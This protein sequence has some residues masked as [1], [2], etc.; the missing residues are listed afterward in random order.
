ME[1]K[2]NKTGNIV[3][4]VFNIIFYLLIGVL[5]VFSVSNFKVKTE[6][7]I[8]NIFG[9]GYL[10]P[11]TDS[12]TGKEKDSFT[13]N[14]LIFVNVLNDKNRIEKLESLKVGD[15]ITFEA[16][17]N[18]LGSKLQLNT[19]R[20]K[21]VSYDESGKLRGFITQ[22]DKARDL[23]NGQVEEVELHQVVAIYTG[24]LNGA[25]S[26]FRFLLT[27]KGFLLCVVLPTVTF[28][29]VEVILLIM[30]FIKIQNAKT[31]EKINENKTIDEEELKEQLRRQ[32]LEE[33]GKT[34]KN[35]E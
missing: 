10:V 23:N 30:N 9:K 2:Q 32:I 5:I 34:D 27:S 8:P 7:N 28:F 4:L 33:M 25:G 6:T 1:S 12:M 19:H 13:P 35:E 15:I 20:I 29:I 24:K 3:K 31:L 17:L 11:I 22:G 18:G 21:E 26:F 16:P 14:D